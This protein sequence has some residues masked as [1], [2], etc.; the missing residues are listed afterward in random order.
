MDWKCEKETRGSTFVRWICNVAKTTRNKCNNTTSI[1]CQITPASSGWAEAVI[2]GSYVFIIIFTAV[3]A[4]FDTAANNDGED[5]TKSSANPKADPLQLIEEKFR[6]ADLRAQPAEGTLACCQIG[7]HVIE[8][9]S[10]RLGTELLA[11][12]MLCQISIWKYCWCST[13][14][15][16]CFFPCLFSS[17]W[18]TPAARILSF[19]RGLVLLHVRFDSRTKKGC[20]WS[21]LSLQSFTVSFQSDHSDSLNTHFPPIKSSKYPPEE[22]KW[23]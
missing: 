20:P 5:D 1:T 21:V 9:T 3:P 14:Y 16:C 6:D 19:V 12:F 2:N 8:E 23:S 7:C 13:L 11:D 10:S 18:H 15:F 4:L 17:P 22:M